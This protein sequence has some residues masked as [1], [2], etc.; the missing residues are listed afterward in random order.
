MRWILALLCLLLACNDDDEQPE[1]FY[2]LSNPLDQ[3]LQDLRRSQDL[4]SPSQDGAQPRLDALIRVDQNLPLQDQGPLQD[5]PPLRLDTD[6]FDIQLP[7]PDLGIPELDLGIPEV[8]M[9]PPES[10]ML[11][12]ADMHPPDPGCEPLEGL[13]RNPSFEQWSGGGPEAWMGAENNLFWIE[14][15]PGRCGRACRLINPEESPH[16]RFTTESLQLSPGYYELS[17]WVRGE[18]EIRSGRYDG[19]HRYGNY[20]AI[21][22][23]EWQQMEYSFHLAQ[24]IFDFELIFSVR[25]APG[26]DLDDVQLIRLAEPCD[27]LECPDWARCDPQSVSC[28]PLSGRCAEA[29]DC[30][31]WQSCEQNRCVI[32]PGRC[33]SIEECSGERPVCDFESHSC[34]EGDP[35][36]EVECEEWERCNPGNALCG[37]APDRCRRSADCLGSLPACNI[38]HHRCE[39]ADHQSNIVVNG[40]FELWELYEIPYRDGEHLLPLGWYGLDF[41]ADNTGDTEI[42]PDQIQRGPG[43]QGGSSCRLEDPNEAD[44]FTSEGFLVP[45][46]HF[47]CVL[48]VRGHGQLRIRS[49]GSN[50]W[51]PYTDRFEVNSEEWFQVP[52]EIRSNSRDMRIIFYASFTQDYIYIDD[53]VCTQD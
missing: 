52:F 14:E 12:S 19:D 51:H 17:Y 9:D 16:Q 30:R 34:I 25:S 18:G 28:E 15:V 53:V 21:H 47:R 29:A 11:P 2:D 8:D 48:W 31:E 1:Y 27:E 6:N 26:L 50:G 41:G 7:E 20:Q 33:S 38:N 22:S 36:A 23:Q 4:I 43:R 32:S 37:L 44:R 46:G 42:R 5:R 49:Y 3:G 40:G 24:E 13:L 35:C 10:D 39:S 45:P